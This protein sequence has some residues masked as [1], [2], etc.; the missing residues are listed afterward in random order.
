MFSWLKKLL[1]IG[2]EPVEP[3]PT[4]VAPAAPAPVAAKPVAKAKPAAEP[5]KVEEKAPKT[6]APTKPK[7][8]EKKDDGL[9]AMNKR[10]LL[11]LAKEKGI[12]SNASMNKD[13]LVKA[14]RSA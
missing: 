3:T 9:D 6:K 11:A 7:K 10:D 5:S 8:E 2:Y 13:A 12:K 14:I 1:G 4:P